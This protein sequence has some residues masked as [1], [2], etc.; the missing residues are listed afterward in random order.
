MARKKARSNVKQTDQLNT[1]LKQ[2]E[3]EVDPNLSI[4][5]NKLESLFNG[6]SD[7]TVRPFKLIGKYPAAIIYLNSIVDKKGINQD[8]L[9]P[10]MNQ[11]SGYSFETLN[12]EQIKTVIYEELIYQTQGSEETKWTS[13]IDH[14]LRG[15][16]IVLVDQ[17][18][19]AFAL[20]TFDV[21]ERSISQPES[22]QVVRGPRDG[23]IESLSTNI[24][25]IRFRLPV[26]SLR[27]KSLNIGQLT[28]SKVAVFYLDSIVNPSLLESVIDRLN[29]I[30]TDRILDAGYLEEHLRD[31]PKSPFPQIQYTERPDVVVGN[32]LEGRVVIIV[33]GSPFGLIAPATI[34]QFLHTPEDYN[35]HFLISSATR[36]IRLISLVLSLI[37]PSLYLA[38]IS[39]HPELI[40]TRF[41]IAITTGRTGVPFPLF[42]EIFIMEIAMEILREATI[43]MP[44]QVGAALSIV[45]VLVVGQAA[46]EAGFVSPLTVVIIALTTIG[47]FATPSYNIAIA[48]RLL[49]FPMLAMT[50]ILGLY[51][52]MISWIIISNHLLSLRSF[53]VPYLQPLS[54]GNWN[55]LKDAIIR[56]PLRWLK[57]RPDAL[58]TKHRQR[59]K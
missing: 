55:D 24:S 39:F 28:Q 9:K 15:Y 47:S 5:I 46:V 57:Y 33:D 25:L 35:E 52:F 36:V 53:G 12:F 37:M 23:F 13:I 21:A 8:I 41:A 58:N 1:M 54:P 10:L 40:P 14:I 31:A 34:T 16:T 38:A 50:T 51:G 20:D 19:L 17:V 4:N 48:L 3:R 45:G 32:L 2:G 11:Q 27:I 42:L 49:R 56:T 30:K 44:K 18:K 6:D 43:R 59:L 26:S 22:E 29:Q 7:F